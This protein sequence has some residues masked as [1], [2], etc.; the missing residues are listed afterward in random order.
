VTLTPTYHPQLVWFGIF[1]STLSSTSTLRSG[2]A[3]YPARLYGGP[4]GAQ[5]VT[6][7]SSVTVSP[8][9][10]PEKG[11]DRIFSESGLRRA[12]RQP[13]PRASGAWSSLLLIPSPARVGGLCDSPIVRTSGPV[14]SSTVR[15]SAVAPRLLEEYSGPLPWGRWRRRAPC[16]HTFELPPYNRPHEKGRGLTRSLGPF[17]V[18]C[19]QAGGGAENYTTFL[20]PPDRAASSEWARCQPLP[21]DSR[22]GPSSHCP[23]SPECVEEKFSEVHIQVTLVSVRRMAGVQS[24]W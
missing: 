16:A 23:Y 13:H 19:F 10:P 24:G 9:P 1:G 22:P 20:P 3:L 21:K 4:L 6:V 17:L 2:I 18:C 8:K 15:C 5:A 7:C 12:R 11:R 14:S